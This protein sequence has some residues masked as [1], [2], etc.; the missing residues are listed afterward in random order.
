MA[1]SAVTK[2]QHVANILGLAGDRVG[3]QP[4]QRGA[5]VRRHWAARAAPSQQLAMRLP[6]HVGHGVYPGALLAVTT[7]PG[8]AECWQVG[9]IIDAVL[10]WLPAL[11]L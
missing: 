8:R 3:D 11:E 2:R 9:Q 10:C 4:Q 5:L 6:S 1:D 7:K